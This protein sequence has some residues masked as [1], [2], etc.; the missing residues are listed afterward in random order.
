MYVF[1]LRYKLEGVAFYANKIPGKRTSHSD[2]QECGVISP[3]NL[4]YKFDLNLQ[5][6]S[7]STIAQTG[8]RD[9]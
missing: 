8:G 5:F 4:D 2:L 9:C 3:V 7:L 1:T 6:S